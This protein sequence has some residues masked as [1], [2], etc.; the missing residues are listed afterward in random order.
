MTFQ[1][2]QYVKSN[3]ELGRA[4]YDL[5]QKLSVLNEEIPVSMF[6]VFVEII[7]PNIK[8]KI[9]SLQNNKIIESIDS[10]TNHDGNI[11][12]KV[13][14]LLLWEISNDTF[15]KDTQDE[16]FVIKMAKIWDRYVDK[17]KKGSILEIE[18]LLSMEELNSDTLNDNELMQIF[19]SMDKDNDGLIAKQD[20]ILFA[21]ITIKDDDQ[22]SKSQQNLIQTLIDKNKEPIIM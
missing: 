17:R 1:S 10:L 22:M 6:A 2:D 13:L 3:A 21:A 9:E 7:D 19:N 12:Y 8:D 18:W 15:S 14:L 20:F 5:H 16:L 4:G 11:H